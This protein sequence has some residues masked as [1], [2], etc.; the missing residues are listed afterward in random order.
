MHPYVL[1]QLR[2]HGISEASDALHP[3]LR[4]VSALLHDVDRERELGAAAMTELS[5]ELESRYERMQQSEQRY[6]LLFDESPI[7]MRRRSP[8]K[9]AASSRGTTPPKRPSATRRRRCSVS[10]SRASGFAAATSACLRPCSPQTF[11][12]RSRERRWKR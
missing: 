7:A 12:F 8:V 6:R 10:R 1:R 3:I 5:R 11:H 2:R 9:T 4:S